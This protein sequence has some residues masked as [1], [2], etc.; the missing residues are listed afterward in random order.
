M[1][2]EFMGAG[3]IGAEFMGAGLMRLAPGDP[4]PWVSGAL[5]VD[6]GES[7]M[8]VCAKPCPGA[9]RVAP[10]AAA[11]TA[12]RQ[13]TLNP[14]PAIAFLLGPNHGDFMLPA[15][16]QGAKAASI[17]DLPR[18]SPYPALRADDGSSTAS[19]CVRMK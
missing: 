5:A 8:R 6:C 15:V 12:Q 19:Q 9:Q 10:T 3:F 1:V 7:S 2:V 18:L 11:A 13:N 14:H 17:A 4:P 16:R